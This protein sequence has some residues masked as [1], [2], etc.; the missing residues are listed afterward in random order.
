[1]LDQNLFT[2]P[3]SEI[4]ETKVLLTLFNGRTVHG[5]FNDLQQ[6]II[7]TKVR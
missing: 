3:A 5:S 4:S 2:V 7:P 6:Q 1:V